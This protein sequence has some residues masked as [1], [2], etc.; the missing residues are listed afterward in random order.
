MV[1]ARQ[2][3]PAVAQP[4]QRVELLDEL[5]RAGAPA[6]RPD[7][8]AVPG[9]RLARDLEDRERDVEAA[10][11]V[12]VAVGR[13]L[14]ALVARRA[15]APGS[16]GSRARA[17]RARSAS[18]GS[19]RARPGR[20]T[21]PGGREVR[22]RP[23]AQATDLPTYSG[24]PVGVAEDV[25]AGL[26]RQ[27]REMSGPGVARALGRRR[28]RP[29]RARRA[30][31][32]G[33]SAS[34][35]PTVAGVRAQPRE[36]RAEHA[37]AGLGVGQRAVR[38]LDLDPERVG[39]RGEPALALQ[40]REP[41]R[42]RDRAQRPAGRATSSAA[43]S[44][45]WR[46]TRG[47]SAALWATS[48]RPRICAGQLGQHALRR[49]RRVDHRLRDPGEALDAA[50]QRRARRRPASPSARA[51]RRRRR[52]PRRP[53]SARTVLAE[54]VGLGVDGEELRGEQ[55]LCGEVDAR[56]SPSYAPRRTPCTFAFRRA[57]VVP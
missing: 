32:G 48:T 4:E 8:D 57:T 51:A 28:A 41:S 26:V 11:Q 54:P 12:D 15:A 17:R 27:R 23:R 39:E 3:A 44:K 55:G 20:S 40:R 38:V 45:A 21:S 19:R 10:A 52:A 47:R 14:E 29:R 50:R 42:Q 2:R 30:G 9:R 22:A 33:S 6:Q 37:R 13:L 56:A 36:Q 5:D 1:A 16:G 31:A 7:G 34:A 53:R 18:P 24:L 43:R 35:S 49:R 25:D 46:S